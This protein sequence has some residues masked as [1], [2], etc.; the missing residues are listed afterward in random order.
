MHMS[1]IRYAKI[2]LEVIIVLVIRVTT[3]KIQHIVLTLM[4]VLT[5]RTIAVRWLRVQIHLVSSTAPAT[6]VSLEMGHFARVMVVDVVCRLMIYIL[7][8]L[9][10]YFMHINQVFS[11]HYCCSISTTLKAILQLFLIVCNI[12]DLVKSIASYEL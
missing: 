4:N 3:Y 11:H 5:R 9:V 2:F 10:V 7:C 8:L 12:D 6:V 1:A